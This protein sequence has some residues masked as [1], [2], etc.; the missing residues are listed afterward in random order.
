MTSHT[1]S[2]LIAALA[3]V[4]S[5]KPPHTENREAAVTGTVAYLQRSALPPDAVLTVQLED[6]S[7]QDAP[8]KVVTQVKIPT[9][10]KQVPIPF[11][12]PYDPGNINPA[13]SYAVR[14][15]IS[16]NGNLMF[17]ST[18]SYRVITQGAP[19]EV[20]IIVQAASASAP[21]EGRSDK[22]SLRLEGTRWKLIDLAGTP[23][24]A[25]SVV[26]EA[27]VT[28]NAEAKRLTGSG[29]C[30]RLMGDYTL[31][32][33]SLRFRHIGSTMMA[34]A[35][36]VMKQEQ[37]FIAALKDTTSYRIMGGTLELLKEQQVLAK[38]EAG[39]PP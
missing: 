25:G 5:G 23:P 18:T 9:A 14:A 21:S 28:L 31:H 7:L 39:S 35:D 33:N 3:L 11:R 17:T 1:M 4:L 2:M 16:E 30:N 20:S 22:A 36:A 27:N 32:R 29:G 34:C 38:L 6:V 8:A 19:I 10:G 24:V 26:E 12:L 13:H 37:G 15:N